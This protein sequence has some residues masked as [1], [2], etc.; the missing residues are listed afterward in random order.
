MKKPLSL[1]PF[2]LLLVL[3][4]AAQTPV[5]YNTLSGVV[6]IDADSSN[7]RNAGEPRVPGILVTLVSAANDSI[8]SSTLSNDTGAFTLRNFTGA[9]TYYINY[10]FP[11]AGYVPVSARTGVIDNINSAADS[12]T[13]GLIDDN[14]VSTPTFS[15]STAAN[16]DVFG[17][18]LHR[19]ATTLTYWSIQPI[20]PTSWSKVFRLPKSNNNLA[21]ASRATILVNQS[22]L[23]PT[24][25][26]ENTGATPDAGA[27]EGSS[28]LTMTPPTGGGTIPQVSTAV[29]KNV[30]FATFDG[31]ADYQGTSGYTWD[32]SY[33]AAHSSVN[34]TNNTQL[35]NVYRT[36]ASPDSLSIS[37]SAV[38]A[39]TITG[40][41]NLQ[42]SV[43]TIS[44]AG[45]FI[46][47]TYPTA[48]PLAINLISF[49]S[50]RDGNTAKLQWQANSSSAAESFVIERGTNGSTFAEI[51]NVG[52]TGTSNEIASKYEFTDIAPGSGLN[53][54]RLKMIDARGVPSFSQVEVLTFG[55][56]AVTASSPNPVNTKMIVVAN[57]ASQIA[58]VNAMGQ[59]V[60][61][62]V[63]RQ[64]SRIILD[65]ANVP[66]G[67]YM[68]HVN[69]TKSGV[70]RSERIVVV[71][72]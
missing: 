17:L 46:T 35:T 61:L 47:Y 59:A 12:T 33:S 49:S 9:G 11:G 66:E 5:L 39:T 2:L 64:F 24:I 1:I 37:G 29:V 68:L 21:T 26:F 65:M 22:A 31:V 50:R 62:S 60:E 40:S 48:V 10:V 57:E 14:T 67:I 71:H 55:D 58:L 44:G 70:V 20:V 7:V 51:G 42:A 18:G 69:D 4:A 56:A 43:S 6:W 32:S 23:H 28:R 36:L 63:T 72:R 45:V 38:S 53:Y 41:A 54:Y 19:I 25:G 16:L 30:A 34:I 13:V 8:V 27:V 15:I 52:A 3:G